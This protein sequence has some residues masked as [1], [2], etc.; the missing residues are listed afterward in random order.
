MR[1]SVPDEYFIV[2]QQNFDG[3]INAMLIQYLKST[4]IKTWLI[5]FSGA[6]RSRSAPPCSATEES[7]PSRTQSPAS[8]TRAVQSPS[9]QTWVDTRRTLDDL[10]EPLE[11]EAYDGEDVERLQRRREEDAEVSE[12]CG[13]EN[14]FWSNL[15]GGYF[16]FSGMKIVES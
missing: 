16:L 14:M 8:T 4:I 7:A 15:F 6:R 5:N 12:G 1:L 9:P 13:L 10:D 2:F 3:W 11:L